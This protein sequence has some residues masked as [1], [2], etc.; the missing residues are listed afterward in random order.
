[1]QNISTCKKTKTLKIWQNLNGFKYFAIHTIFVAT[2]IA[3][4][5]IAGR[6]V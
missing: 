2:E 1:M 4:F 5:G 6:A 3:H